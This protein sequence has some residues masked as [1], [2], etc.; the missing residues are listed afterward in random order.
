MDDDARYGRTGYAGRSYL[1]SN[2][3]GY[4]EP[5][6]GYGRYPYSDEPVL[7]SRDA[8][9]QG[10]SDEPVSWTYTEA[11]SVPGPYTGRGPGGYLHSDGRIR[12]QVNDRLFRHGQID[13]SDINASVNNGE[14]TLEGTVASRRQKR[15]ADDVADSVAG[16]RDVHNRLQIR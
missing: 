16:V 7:Y 11:W 13:A 3:Y 4:S 8:G 10:S 5:S 1:V 2:R 14:V 15:M 12:D 6:L 9:R